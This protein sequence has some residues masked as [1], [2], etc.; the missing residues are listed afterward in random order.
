MIPIGSR[1][2]GSRKA[3]CPGTDSPLFMVPIGTTPYP[4][5]YAAPERTAPRSDGKP[6]R[7]TALGYPAH[8]RPGFSAVPAAPEP[9]HQ[10]RQLGRH[11]ASHPSHGQ[12]RARSGC[13]VPFAPALPGS[14]KGWGRVLWCATRQRYPVRGR[15]GAASYGALPA[16]AAAVVR[17]WAVHGA[18]GTTGRLRVSVKRARSNF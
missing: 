2:I 10:R 12:S 13:P 14:G 3:S 4:Q 15:A 8:A 1:K 7:T 11:G 18:Y 16:S 5:L 17:L 9:K 6:A